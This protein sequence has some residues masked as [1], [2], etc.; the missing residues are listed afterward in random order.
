M[1]TC[2]WAL[3]GTGGETVAWRFTIIDGRRTRLFFAWH[4]SALAYGYMRQHGNRAMQERLMIVGGAMRLHLLQALVG[5]G[6]GV[7]MFYPLR[8]RQIGVDLFGC[9]G[10]E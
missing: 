6:D 4:G 8:R 5:T 10:H 1:G 9:H 2:P 7:Q 3:C